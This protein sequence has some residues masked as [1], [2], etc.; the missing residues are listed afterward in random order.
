L[1]T[2]GIIV[3][4]VAGYGLPHCLR[5]TVGTAEEIGLVIEVLTE[6]MKALRG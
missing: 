4:K 1:R 6:F 5:V 3:R 2:R